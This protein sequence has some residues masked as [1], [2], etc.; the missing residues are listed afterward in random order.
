MKNH[1]I[2]SPLSGLF[3]AHM[4][5]KNNQI[6]HMSVFLTKLVIN[7]KLCHKD[8][9]INMRFASKK[10]INVSPPSGLYP[11]NF[12]IYINHMTHMCFCQNWS[13][14]AGDIVLGL[15]GHVDCQHGVLF[16]EFSAIL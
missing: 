4:T 16:P 11:A 10:Q 13:C 14:K 3:R 8:N 6:F 1:L 5:K 7:V 2:A 9:F 15:S 12:K